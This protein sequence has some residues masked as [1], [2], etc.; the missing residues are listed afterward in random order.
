[1]SAEYLS[2][3]DLMVYLKISAA[4][5]GRLMQGGLPY[6]KINRK[7]LFKRSDIDKWLESKRVQ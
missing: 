4:T 6:F 2:K 3:K 1:M 5:V 7:V